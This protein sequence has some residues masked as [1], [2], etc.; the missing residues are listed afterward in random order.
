MPF[1]PIALFAFRRPRHVGLALRSLML[2]PELA[3]SPIHI[4]CDGPRNAA[5]REAVDAAPECGA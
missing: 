3:A 1:A 4:Y 2:N 5:D